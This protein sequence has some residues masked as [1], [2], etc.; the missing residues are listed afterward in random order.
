[1][2]TLGQ[3]GEYLILHS[4]NTEFARL[5]I[6]SDFF[7]EATLPQTA[8]FTATMLKFLYEAVLQDLF[9]NE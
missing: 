2:L 7:P 6:G 4:L 5:T 9:K 3:K 1:M 8:K